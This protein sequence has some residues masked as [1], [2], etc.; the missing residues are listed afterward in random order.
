VL[1]GAC[2]RA[3]A[4]ESV[5]VTAQL[6][7]R[8]Y[9]L[10]SAPLDSADGA[11]QSVVT[12]AQDITEQVRAEQERA[13]ERERRARLEGMLFAARQLADRM[14][15]DLA[16]SSGAIDQLQPQLALPPELRVAMQTVAA[17]VADMMEKMA[18]LERLIYPAPSEQAARP[19]SDDQP[20]TPSA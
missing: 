2:R 11:V 17:T 5:T 4:G 7:D 8:T 18:E 14:K 20:S 9:T 13:E 6:D 12:V 16:Q 10:S 1:E 15:G 3:F 19:A